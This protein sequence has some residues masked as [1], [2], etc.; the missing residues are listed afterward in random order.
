MLFASIPSLSYLRSLLTRYSLYV[1]AL[2]PVRFGLGAIHKFAFRMTGIRLS[3]AI[4]LHYL[5]HLFGQRIHVLDSLPPGQAVGTITATSNILQ[6]GISEK[7]GI[8][9]EYSCLII[10]ALIIALK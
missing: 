4:R 10:A 1:F 6:L 7:L 2:F 5:K 9:D 3:A 8:F